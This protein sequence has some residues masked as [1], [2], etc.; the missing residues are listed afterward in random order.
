MFFVRTLL[1]AT[2]LGLGL[3]EACAADAP[4]LVEKDGRHALMVDGAPFLVLG[5]QI[6]N[7]SSWPAVLPKVWPALEAMHV[8]TAEAPMYWEQM[9]PEPGRSTFRRRMRWWRGRA[10]TTCTWSCCG[11]GRGRT[12]ICTMRRSG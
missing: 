12:A 4:K 5:A 10:L 2:L 6:N 11:L 3:K 9:E 8:N 7:S 1:F